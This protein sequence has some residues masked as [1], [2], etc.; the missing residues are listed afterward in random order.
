LD[1]AV[2]A[3]DVLRRRGGASGTAVATL[4]VTTTVGYGVLFYA[5]GV[6]LGPMQD[7]LGWSRSFLTGAFSGALLIG[8][9]LTIVVG[10]WLDHHPPRM[11][12]LI[13]SALGTAFV[14]A[15][16]SVHHKIAFVAVWVV[17][18][19][20]QSVLFYEPAFTVLTK[21]FAGRDRQ[22]AVTT[23]TLLAGLASTI[24]GPLTAALEHAFGWRGAVY[25]LAALLGTITIPCFAFGLRAPDA[26]PVESTTSALDSIPSEVMV[27][28]QFWLLTTA[29]LLNAITTY[30]I[31]VHV[32]PFLRDRGLSLSTGASVLGAL[33]LVQVLGR[34]TFTRLVARRTALELGSW[35]LVA[36]AA[37]IALLL[38]IHG[39]IGI[40]LFVI[41]YGAANGMATLTRATAVAELYGARHYGSIA[42]V[43]ASVGAVGGALAPFAVARAID[44]VGSDVPVF[45]GL[46]VL[47]LLGAFVHSM[48]AVDRRPQPASVPASEPL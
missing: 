25:G 14:V 32:V 27:S 30:A 5:Y 47:S 1:V 46:A 33:G 19:G 22:R 4:A 9:A 35:V 48:V 13:G 44:A 40:V 41:V 11:M 43:V 36:K 34:S 31:A 37:G 10:R 3:P 45:W 15:W 39:T 23:V 8:A 38:L 29:Y 12:F 16:G 7:D 6:L 18:G 42:S 20:C 21:W 2:A 26:R 24:F 28:R 17:L